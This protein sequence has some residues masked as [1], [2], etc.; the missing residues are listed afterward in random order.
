LSVEIVSVEEPGVA[1]ILSEA[2]VNLPE[3]LEG[4]E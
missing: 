2:G 1:E 4:P 3:V